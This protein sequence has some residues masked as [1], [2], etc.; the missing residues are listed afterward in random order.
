MLPELAKRSTRASSSAKSSGKGF[1]FRTFGQGS[2]TRSRRHFDTLA[3]I[4][5]IEDIHLH[6]TR[7]TMADDHMPG[8]MDDDDHHHHR[9]PANSSRNG[10]EDLIIQHITSDFRRPS[11]LTPS[12][13][14]ADLGSAWAES[15]FPKVS[16]KR[17]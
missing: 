5:A 15:N 13:Q 3:E 6:D 2:R 14:E 8:T 4:D 16:V 10:S 17:M 12:S 11:G 9:T 7:H 1:S